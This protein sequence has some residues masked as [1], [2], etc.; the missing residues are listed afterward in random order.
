MDRWNENFATARSAFTSLIERAG[1][2]LDLRY[3]LDG[4]VAWMRAQQAEVNHTFNPELNGLTPEN[5]FWL[6]VSRGDEIVAC[7][8]CRLFETDHYLQDI[9]RGRLWYAA[10]EE[11]TELV[12]SPDYVRI[13]GRIGHHGGCFITKACRGQGFPVVLTRL[14]RAITGTLWAP[15]WHAGMIKQDPPPAR[16]LARKYGY[17]WQVPIIRGYSAGRRARAA[18]DMTLIDRAAMLGQALEDAR[19]L[20]FHEGGDMRDVAAVLTERTEQPQI[21]L[22]TLAEYAADQRELRRQRLGAYRLQA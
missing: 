2:G 3:D 1:Y 6:A 10:P 9:A 7:I 22:R 5:C 19:T 13:D 20:Q 12:V 11:E 16:D 18:V 14:T 8:A 15:D 4:W 17:R 21:R